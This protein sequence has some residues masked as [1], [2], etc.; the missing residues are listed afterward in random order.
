MRK[1]SIKRLECIEGFREQVAVDLSP[2]GQARS[3]RWKIMR[4]SSSC[5]YSSAAA[6]GFVPKDSHGLDFGLDVGVD[7]FPQ[8]WV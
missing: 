1:T 7:L 2:E 8:I 6:R 3:K 5:I 4:F